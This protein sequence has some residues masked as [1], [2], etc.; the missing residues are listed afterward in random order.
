MEKKTRVSFTKE[1]LYYLQHIIWHFADYIGLDDRPDHGLG[2][3]KSYRDLSRDKKSV[4][5]VM[6]GKLKRHYRKL[7]I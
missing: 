5:A 6:A 4:I 7:T 1:E 2:I 3:L